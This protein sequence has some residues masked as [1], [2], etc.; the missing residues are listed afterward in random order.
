MMEA[1][2]ENSEQRHELDGKVQKTLTAAHRNKTVELC[3]IMT[4]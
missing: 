3:V 2:I 4:M 1:K